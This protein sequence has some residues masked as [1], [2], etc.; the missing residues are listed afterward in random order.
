MRRTHHWHR[1]NGARSNG[2]SAIHSGSIPGAAR[3]RSPG[4]YDR[5]NPSS[6]FAA[7]SIAWSAERAGSYIPTPVAYEGGLYVL[8]DTGILARYDAQT[9]A[10]S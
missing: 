2:S 9:G 4:F 5:M 10:L 6:S 3:D 7:Q 1:P 8:Y